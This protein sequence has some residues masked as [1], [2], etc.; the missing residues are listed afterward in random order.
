MNTLY[1]DIKTLQQHSAVHRP[2]D[3]NP[4][5]TQG[6]LLLTLLLDRNANEGNNANYYEK[7]Y[8]SEKLSN[9][10]KIEMQDQG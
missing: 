4:I 6:A 7:A 1:I 3:L 5:W 2:V 10:S 8:W 9:Y